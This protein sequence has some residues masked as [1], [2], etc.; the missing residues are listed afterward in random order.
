MMETDDVGK[1]VG[2]LIKLCPEFVFGYLES[3]VA[4]QRF[5]MRRLDHL[6]G[7]HMTITEGVTLLR[8]TVTNLEESLPEARSFLDG[9]DT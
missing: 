5:W 9:L 1:L 8:D 4:K 7:V 6:H 2:H 3:D